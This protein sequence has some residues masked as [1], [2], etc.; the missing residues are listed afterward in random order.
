[1]KKSIIWLMMFVVIMGTVFGGCRKVKT[2]PTP[3][4]ELIV[5]FFAGE[6]EPTINTE[7]SANTA[8]AEQEE[9]K[10]EVSDLMKKVYNGVRLGIAKEGQRAFAIATY[11]ENGKLYRYLHEPIEWS[12]VEGEEDLVVLEPNHYAAECWVW[13]AGNKIGKAKIMATAQSGYTDTADIY[14]VPDI[15]DNGSIA[16]IGLILDEELWMSYPEYPGLGAKVHWRN[17]NADIVFD[18]EVVRFPHGATPLPD[19]LFGGWLFFDQ[20]D[21]ETPI[22][23]EMVEYPYNYSDIYLMLDGKGRK[24]ALYMNHSNRDPLRY[25]AWHAQDRE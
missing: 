10:V 12:M 4:R 23:E 3:P 16:P 22:E 17:E 20:I 5:G 11:E 15:K 1:M 24:I 7:G 2:P 6:V 9:R 13:A 14:I 8:Q 21:W 19:L 18:R 25:I